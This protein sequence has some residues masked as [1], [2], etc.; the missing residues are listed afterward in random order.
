MPDFGE[1]RI[2]IVDDDPFMQEILDQI[3]RQL[4]VCE[5]WK[6]GD[7]LVA[8]EILD[9]APLPIDIVLCDLDMSGMDGIS[10][11]R[12]LSERN[13]AGGILVMSGSG[14]R[15]VS[16]VADLVQEHRL[17][18]LGAMSKPPNAR[19]IA[20]TLANYDPR[21]HRGNGVSSLAQHAEAFTVEQLR[22]G[23]EQG[24][25]DIVVQPQVALHDRRLVGC[26]VLL[27]WRDPD[28]GGISPAEVIPIA[29]A[30]G[31]I[32]EL[33]RQ[34]L[35]RSVRCLANFHR[36][37]VHVRMSVNVSAMNLA[38]TVFPDELATIV[39]EANLSPRDIVIEVTEGR[40]FDQ[41]AV[42]TDVLGRLSLFGFGLSI[43]DFGT[44][45]SG[46]EKL[47]HLPFTELKIDRT[48]VH[49]AAVDPSL[50]VILRTAVTLGRS[51]GMTV[52]A[53]GVEDQ[54]D[55][56]FLASTGCDEV[57]GYLVAKPMPT[58]DFPVWA[59]EWQRT[60]I[61]MQPSG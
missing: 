7:G 54:V 28:R 31:L 51:L 30:N 32:D 10:C 2:L 40:I 24:Y 17:N 56:D 22:T 6:A 4:G 23:L 14:Q 42:T 59:A 27:R 48:F 37:G 16:S 25:A 20:D 58:S 19:D 8:L 34:I 43:D 15:L 26:E 53:E 61:A 3:L 5:I 38:R 9:H 60:A 1:L 41:P 49:G 47:R 29:E 46:L 11:I 50:A 39:A 18:L 45:Y 44:G 36:L 33:T 35:Q 12:H 57:Q 13:F 52:V 21:I 55:W